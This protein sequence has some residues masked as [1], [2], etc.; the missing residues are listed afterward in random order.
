MEI[1]SYKKTPTKDNRIFDYEWVLSDGYIWRWN[2]AIAW[3]IILD[4]EGEIVSGIIGGYQF[5]THYDF[6]E[7]TVVL[8]RDVTD[9]ELLEH[10][11]VFLMSPEEKTMYYE[12]KGFSE[13]N[14]DDVKEV[15]KYVS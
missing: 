13:F 14:P 15:W 11:R 8:Y 6:F 2:N 7:P 4:P 10:H 9:E 5:F 3:P 1:I 12:E